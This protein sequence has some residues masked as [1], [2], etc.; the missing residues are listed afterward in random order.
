MC[1]N[2]CTN[3]HVDAHMHTYGHLCV[4]TDICTCIHTQ[5]CM[6]THRFPSISKITTKK[7]KSFEEQL[8][9]L[10]SW[11]KRETK[12]LAFPEKKCNLHENNYECE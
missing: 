2:T 3:M 4:Q 12:F 11:L 8:F 10:F 1:M 6:H 9:V 7:M 5:T